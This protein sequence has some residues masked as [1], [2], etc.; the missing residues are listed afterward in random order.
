M[1]KSLD[2]GDLASGVFADP[3]KAFETVEHQILRSKLDLYGIR[4]LCK[5]WFKSYLSDRH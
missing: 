4:G 1:R 5:D 3:Q 2:N